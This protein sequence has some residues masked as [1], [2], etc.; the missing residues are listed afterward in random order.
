MNDDIKQEMATLGVS[1]ICLKYPGSEH[2]VPNGLIV[3]FISG[4]SLPIECKYYSRHM[5]QTLYYELK[6]LLIKSGYFDGKTITKIIVLLSKAWRERVENEKR[7]EVDKRTRYEKARAAEIA[8]IDAE[9]G[10]IKTA[11]MGISSEQWAT[12]LS[13]R[14]TE[15]RNTVNAN[16]PE[17]WPG[18]EFELS[19]LRILNIQDCTLPFIGILL[20]RPSSYKTIVITLLKRWYCTFYT[21]SF[22]PKSWITHT[23]AVDSEEDLMRID[24]LPKVKD[25]HF[26]TPELAP[27]FTTEEKD[28]GLI[29][30]TIT[31][32]ADGHGYGSDSGAH[33][34][35]EYGDTMFV[36]TGAAVDIPYKV[37][38][39]LA[40]LGFKLY[41]FRLPYK[42]KTED[43]LLK[44]MKERFSKKKSAIEAALYDYLI[45]FEIG[46]DLIYDELSHLRR[47]RWDDDRDDEQAQRWIIRLA[48]VLKHLRCIAKTWEIEDDSQGSNYGYS[49]TQPE[50]PERAI[51]VLRNLAR[52]HALL[53]G[54]NY[55][56]IEDIPIVVKTVLSTANIDKV[57][58]F[59][60]LIEN[61][62]QLQTPQIQDNLN[63]ARPTALRNMVEL[64]AIGLVDH[65]E[66]LV[67]RSYTKRITLKKE[68]D[69]LLTEEF[70]KLREGFEPVDNRAFMT[71]DKNEGEVKEDPTHKGKQDP[72]THSNN[73]IYSL[74]QVSIFWRIFG[75][76]ESASIQDSD[77]DTDRNT[78]SG[79][80]LQQE[81]LSTGKI[82]QSD[83]AMLIEEMCRT[84]FIEK[85]SFDT[86]KR[87]N[88]R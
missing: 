87:R 26:L 54:R 77:I 16:I 30:G 8:A 38:K 12:G 62:G 29:L 67:G 69:W 23:T 43:E 10:R 14:F 47:M 85:V 82:F 46:P 15:L 32:I 78:V 53:T 4:N 83:A 76:L 50:S 73:N 68:F 2:N 63:V 9:V 44:Q 20:G 59:R 37:Y 5:K 52:G 42:D 40:G 1:K 35:R 22:S 88:K 51:E 7:E 34:H 13:E 11:N 60:L 71:P 6:P 72:Y 48:T 33:G 31:R 74:E 57:G 21:D 19:S 17:I 61:G 56:I 58:I 41:F 28:L 64:K 27:I 65:D 75:E 70:E 45:W 49:V 79:Q 80:A 39:L 3:Y 86:Y 66:I 81:L 84:E 18:L 55:I 25:R 36:W 24:M